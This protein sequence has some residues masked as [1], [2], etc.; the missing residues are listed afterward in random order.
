MAGDAKAHE[1]TH[2]A[3]Q[4]RRLKLPEA[5]KTGSA[6]LGVRYQEGLVP[7]SQFT[8]EITVDAPLDTVFEFFSRAEDLEKI[9]PRSLRFKILTPLPIEM[10]TGTLIEYRIRLFGIPFKWLSEITVWE[11]ERRFVDVQRNGPYRMWEHEHRFRREGSSTR[12]WDTVR[13]E[14]PGGL[15]SPILDALFVRKQVKRIFEHRAAAIKQ[16][17][18]QT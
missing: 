12:M 11:P 10:G 3:L 15:F 6:S 2:E 5:P 4:P 1:P 14:P 8:T 18:Q 16:A 7:V 17:M 9:T 13:F